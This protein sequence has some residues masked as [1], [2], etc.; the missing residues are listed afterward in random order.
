MAGLALALDAVTVRRGG[1][2]VLGPVTL[3]VGAGQA[4]GVIGPNCAGKTTLLLT[5]AG[6][7]RP[8][9]GRVRRVREDG[10]RVRRTDVGLLLQHCPEPPPVPLSVLEVVLL[11]MVGLEAPRGPGWRRREREAALS[12][13]RELGM[14]ALAHRRLDQLSGG[15]RCKAHIARLLLQDAR[16]LLLDEPTT[17]LDPAWRIRVVELLDALHAARGV[18]L[19]V[20]AHDLHHLP[21]RTT[22]VAVLRGGSL[23]AAGP[24][25][26]ALR[27]E[28]L[29]ELYGRQV[30]PVELPPDAL[31]VPAMRRAEAP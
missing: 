8:A 3:E 22:H 10:A 2:T 15:E 25:R 28:V 19:V 7:L 30:R 16:V 29:S 23:L 26:E 14:E 18:T 20:A 6:V 9:S 17:S 1:R 12:V 5:L 11:G 27:P 4:W 21:G 31:P 13:L 24:R